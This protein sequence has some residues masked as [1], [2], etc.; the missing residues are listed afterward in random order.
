MPMSVNERA[1][2][3]ATFRFIEVRIME[4][5]AAWTPSTP[6]MEVKVLFGRHIWGFAQH[7]DALGKR[8]FE[9]RQ[10]MHYTVAPEQAYLE[11]LTTVAALRTTGDRIGSLYDVVLP[12]LIRRYEAYVAQTDPILDEPTVVIMERIVS[13]LKRQI[14]ESKKLQAEVGPFPAN[15]TPL[16]QQEQSIDRFVTAGR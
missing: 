2:T 16:G 10:P 9:L 8:T 15:V 6:E 7:A 3:V 13:D 5:V 14:Q 11:F 4:I 1:R 12:G